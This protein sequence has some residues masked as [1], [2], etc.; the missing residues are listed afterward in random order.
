M[1]AFRKRFGV[2]AVALIVVTGFMAREVYA[3][4][5]STQ[6]KPAQTKPVQTATAANVMVGGRTL[7]GNVQQGSDHYLGNCASCHGRQ[8]QSF[9]SDYPRLSAQLPN[10]TAQQLVAFRAGKREGGVMNQIASGLTDQ[11]IADLATSLAAS[12]VA[13]PWKSSDA[14][15]KAQGKKLYTMGND[16]TGLSACAGCH[17]VDG[18]GNAAANFPL[19]AGQSPKYFTERIA[20]LAKGNTDGGPTSALM[21]RVAKAMT[22]ADTRALDEYIKTLPTPSAK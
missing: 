6:S 13:P 15:L 21:V 16:A 4:S 9:L 7:T 18:R 22:P 8:G 1:S 2:S 12:P 3:Q 19:I 11:Q 14:A 10:Y 5:K 20:D 17:G